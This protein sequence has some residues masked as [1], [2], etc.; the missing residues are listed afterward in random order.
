MD[1]KKDKLAIVAT[2]DPTRGQAPYA[3]DSYEIWGLAVTA[4]YPDVKRMDVVF[5]MHNGSY[6]DKGDPNVKKRLVETKVPLVML[7][8]HDDIPMSVAYPM[9]TITTLYRRYH[10]SSISYIMAL[11]YHSFLTTGKPNHVELYGVHMVGQ[12]EYQD[13]RPCC[14]YWAGVMEGAGMTMVMPDGGSLL[15]APGLYGL[16]NY[17]PVCW[18]MRQYLYGVQAGLA[19]ETRKL[20]AAELQ[21]AKQEGAIYAVEHW[22]LKFQRGEL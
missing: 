20:R 9:E 15:S 11:A 7:E 10:T 16:E 6:W 19:D 2:A 3:D 17:N 13:Q 22:L 18:E 12:A 21:K 14:E 8:K 5:E 1:C 4:T